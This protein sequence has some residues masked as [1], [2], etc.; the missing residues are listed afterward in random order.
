MT[1]TNP[2]V[3]ANNSTD[4]KVT[5]APTNNENLFD[6]LVGEGKKFKDAQALAKAKAESDAFIEQLKEENANLREQTKQIKSTEEIVA[7]IKKELHSASESSRE[8]TAPE[9]DMDKISELV[10]QQLG[11]HEHRKVV[12]ANMLK[13]NNDMIAIY[14]DKAQEMVASKAAAMGMSMDDMKA[15]AAKSPKAFLAM[16]GVDGKG[17]GTTAG[18]NKGTVNTQA[19]ANSGKTREDTYGTAE[20]WSKQRKELGAKFWDPKIQ[21]EV[22][23]CKKEGIY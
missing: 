14:G 18:V 16:F 2:D 3:F 12:E 19:L 5:D 7:A 15:I 10:Q 13:A 22:F 11:S 1:Q 21:Q 8:Q 4:P 23:K 6:T 17:Q 20:Y 9:L